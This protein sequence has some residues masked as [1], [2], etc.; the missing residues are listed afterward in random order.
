M[1]KN[2]VLEN[3]DPVEIYGAG[4][5]VLEALCGWF[6]Q[7][8][9]AARGNLSKGCVEILLDREVEECVMISAVEKEGFSVDSIRS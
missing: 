3:T 6:P 9:V 8:R 5:R 2:I 1:K 4:N 7:L